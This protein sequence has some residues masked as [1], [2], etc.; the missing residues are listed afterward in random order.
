M[1]AD[2]GR[3]GPRPE[4]DGLPPD[5]PAPAGHVFAPWTVVL[6]QAGRNTH[7]IQVSISLRQPV[8]AICPVSTLVW[9]L[10]FL[11]MCT[12]SMFGALSSQCGHLHCWRMAFLTLFPHQRMSSRARRLNM[13]VRQTHG[14]AW[15]TMHEAGSRRNPAPW[16][17]CPF[18]NYTAWSVLDEAEFLR[19]IDTTRWYGWDYMLTCFCYLGSRAHSG[20]WQTH[21]RNPICPTSR[22]RALTSR[23]GCVSTPPSAC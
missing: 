23:K 13:G 8:G 6:V 21:R 19:D 5:C 17:L 11:S 14:C 3:T 4:N 9:Y 20:I 15:K 7:D 1:R 22:T 18:T 10:V 12:R 2:L 16:E